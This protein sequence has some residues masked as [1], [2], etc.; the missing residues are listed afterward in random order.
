M[1]ICTAQFGSG[2]ASYVCD[3]VASATERAAGG[4]VEWAL[5]RN[6]ILRGEYLLLDFG[7]VSVNTPTTISGAQLNS[8]YNTVRS[9]ADLTAQMLRLGLNY[10]F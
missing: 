3:V 6:W 4:G 8:D 1:P 10:K 7:K 2:P 9:T 5:N